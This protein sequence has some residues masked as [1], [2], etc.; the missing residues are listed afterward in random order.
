MKKDYPTWGY[1][2]GD[3]LQT[4]AE[5]D[6]LADALERY[7]KKFPNDKIELE[8]DMRVDKQGRFLPRGSMVG[9]SAYSTDHEHVRKFIDFLRICG[10]FSIF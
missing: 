3:G 6:E 2:D 5:C 8:S 10:G 4:Q 1:N 9:E 7:L